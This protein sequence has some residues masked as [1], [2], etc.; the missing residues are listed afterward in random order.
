M[1]N[2]KTL[3]L[4]ASVLFLLA[5]FAL[6]PIASAATP[7]FVTG[8][9]VGS[10]YKINFAA[11]ADGVTWTNGT[12]GSINAANYTGTASSSIYAVTAGSTTNA[13]TANSLAANG[14]NCTAGYYPLGIDS[15]GNAEGCTA[16]SGG[17]LGGS[18]TINYV[19]KWS[20]V[21]N[22]ANS[23]L[24]DNGTSVGIGTTDPGA[25]LDIKANAS[26]DG[27][28]VRATN[29]Y[30]ILKF[31]DLSGVS[32]AWV[33]ND[34]GS[35]FQFK[36]FTSGGDLYL[37]TTGTGRTIID[38]GN[39]GIGLTNPGTKLDVVGGAIRTNNQLIST[40]AAGTAPLAVTS[41]TLVSNLNADLLDGDHASALSVLYAVSAGSATNAGSANSLAANG[42][43]CTVGNYPLGVDAAGNVE[44]C[45]ALP[46]AHNALTIAAIG[47][48]PNANGMTLST[49]QLNLE[50]ASASFGG[51]VTTGAQTF[52]GAKTFNGGII[53]ALTG[54]ASTATA[55][56]AN[57][58][59]CSAG[60]Y[61]LG[62]DASGNAESCTA[63]PGGISGSGTL[64]YVTK[65]S[66]ASG[67]TTSLLFDNGTNVGIGL[68]NPTAKLDVSGGAIRTNNQ[69]IS[70]IAAGTAPLVV[71]SN[72][73]VSNLNADLLDGDHA[74]NL[75]VLY[76]ATAGTA[77]AAATATALGTNGTNCSAGYYPLGVDEKG[78]VES[79]T[80]DAGADNLGNHRATQNIMMSSNWI[81]NDGDN[82]GILISSTGGAIAIS[83][84]TF[85]TTLNLGGRPG[86]DGIKFPDGTTQTTAFTGITSSISAANVSAGTFGAN[87]GG[88]D[89]RFPRNVGIGTTP[90]Y[91]LDVYGDAQVNGYLYIENCS[92]SCSRGSIRV[93][94]PIG[95]MLFEGEA[96]YDFS[97]YIRA[98]NDII[99]YQNVVGTTGL[100]MNSDC[101]SSWGAAMAGTYSNLAS[102]T[103]AY[104]FTS[105]NVFR[106][107]P[108][109]SATYTA[110]VGAAGQ[111]GTI[112]ILTSGTTSRTITF[113]SGFK[114]NG[115]LATGTTSGK[116][117]VLT[118]V[119]D[120]TY[121]I[122]TS[123]TTAL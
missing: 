25:G 47:T 1:N 123:R 111:H 30:Q 70:T 65:W 27:L 116:Y 24:F 50:P 68:T 91:S 34:S 41:N 55:L 11:N 23:L 18:G 28:Y 90:S 83:T 78:N 86:V 84:T 118:Y 88:G 74:S 54:N 87:T 48:T 57:G 108:T 26:T 40:I 112:I 37:T 72:T 12:G 82:E 5:I 77:T 119:S 85:S 38:N 115:T 106:V 73:L 8:L 94:G 15:A 63:I 69:L 60:N 62:V 67:I 45:T 42:S 99:S 114:P 71:T 49:Q 51:I 100:C 10:G 59:N 89:Y 113:G 16:S 32:R 29:G 107:T 98:N 61:P 121:M 102:G 39:V 21:S 117:F 56:A 93:N 104:N 4:P 2:K 33:G 58:T 81:S 36:N 76:A 80:A 120:G 7:N 66:G 53:G 64:N 14:S 97:N 109:A 9:G 92:G 35:R 96:F 75:S 95:S 101:R 13:Q 19:P 52:A 110:T 31:L 3:I 6:A 122:E 17:S 105:T 103:T 22:L 44:S 20:S 46:G 43:N 79:C